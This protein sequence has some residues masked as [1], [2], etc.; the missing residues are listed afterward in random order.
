MVVVLKKL[1]LAATQK[2]HVKKTS[3]PSYPAFL[4]GFVQAERKN[5]YRDSEYQIRGDENFAVQRNSEAPRQ[6]SETHQRTFLRFT[7]VS[8]CDK[9]LHDTGR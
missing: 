6:F 7:A 8:S 4:F 1:F 2:H 9:K 3:I 5:S